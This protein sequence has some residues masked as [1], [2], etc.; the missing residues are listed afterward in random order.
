MRVLKIGSVG[1]DVME[2]QS[3]LR[4]LGFYFGEIDG[5]YGNA[6]ANAVRN[7]QRGFG[8]TVDGT[9]GPET[10]K[11]LEPFLK[12]YTNYTIRPGDTLYYISDNF[13]TNVNRILTANPGLDPYNLQIG[14]E[15]IVPFGIGIV[16]TRIDY[17]YEIM[18]RDLAGLEAVFPYLKVES[19]GKSVLGKELYYIKIGTG[20]NKVFYNAAHHSLEWITSP[21]LM[22]FTENLAAAYSEG[23]L[24]S[25]YNVREI[26]QRSTIYIMPMVNPDGVDLVLNGLSTDNPYYDDLL[27]WNDTGRPFSEVWQ[28]NIRGVDLNHNYDAAWDLSKQAELEL[29]IVGPGPTRYSGPEPFSEPETRAVR[30]LT[31][32]IAPRLVLAYHSQGEVIYWDFMDLAPPESRPIGEVLAKVSGYTLEELFGIASYAGYKDWFIQD[33]GRP[34]YTV[35]VGLGVNPLPISQFPEIYRA[36]EPLLLQATLE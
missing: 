12:G 11:A 6:T 16:D 1:T 34:G 29:G 31:I 28:A 13:G 19:A 3:M 18:E 25:G 27:K 35:E 8:L 5:I 21:L 24:L 22:K 9:V 20:G 26:L 32:N 4:S 2:I 15:I 14:E 10:F 23:R 17:T 7:F 30:D 33:F 36:N